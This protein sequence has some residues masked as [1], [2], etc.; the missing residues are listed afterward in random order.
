ME[1][2]GYTALVITGP[3]GTGKSELG[4]EVAEQIDGEI[5]SADSRQIYRQMDIGTAK[6]FGALLARVPHHGLDCIDPDEGYSAGRFARGARERVVDIRKRGRVP[7]IVGG[8][9]LFV[10]ALLTPLAP[11]PRA[12]GEGRARLRE[13]LSR[14]SVDRLKAWLRRLDPE[15]AAQLKSEGGPQRLARSLE[16]VLLSGR[17]HS[18]WMRLPP[19]SPPLPALVFCLR[20]ERE[21]LY[22]R[23][24][25]RFDLMMAAGLLDEVRSLLDRYPESAPGLKSVGYAELI[26]H[27]RGGP[28]FADAVE[29]AKRSTR[30]FARRQLTWFRHQLPDSAVWLDADLP[31]QGL[32]GE[33]VGRWRAGPPRAE[34]GHWPSSTL[35]SGE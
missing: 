33:I 11:E 17:K 34:A 2:P 1:Q 8:T 25:E 18:W 26:A 27:L 30:R 15:R 21:E 12:D 14:Y 13:Y 7:I 29:S 32:V 24:D 20:L 3:T 10:R 22:R 16:V 23:I 9:G 19:D 28:A 31:R 4:V 5:V 35:A 6:P